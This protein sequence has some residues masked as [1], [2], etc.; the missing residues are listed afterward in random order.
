MDI[1]AQAAFATAT[2]QSVI[3]DLFSFPDKD[4]VSEKEVELVAAPAVGSRT[5]E[6]AEVADAAVEAV[7]TMRPAVAGSKH[8]GPGFTAYWREYM[9][10]VMAAEEKIN[11]LVNAS[12]GRLMLRGF[13]IGE[14]MSG[15]AM[16]RQTRKEIMEQV[17]SR[18]ER[19]F[20]P[21]SG[22]LS[23]SRCKHED[24]LGQ[25]WDQCDDES[26]D[27]DAVWN[28]LEGIYGGG[29]GVELG[30][31]QI[32]AKLVDEFGLRYSKPV[33]KANRLELTD[34]I[35]CEKRYDGTM[36]LSYRSAELVWQLHNAMSA[37]CE[38]AGDF[39]TA[40]KINLRSSDMRMNRNR[41]VV[42]R[43]R[44]DMGG[45]G[46]VM[47]YKSMTWEIYGDLG[48]QFQAFVGKYGREAIARNY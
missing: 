41:A 26:F 23:I 8:E 40:R 4:E 11:A 43:A 36:E 12:E 30:Y 48:D 18:A 39:E 37:F 17:Y 10:A 1:E 32:A 44:F 42:S 22:S 3:M 19:E 34:S 28:A 20:A 6:A 35:Y 31:K 2:P 24:L 29:Y 15:Y 21:Q 14:R 33:R 7:N 38:W 46:Y 25:S 5:A 16:L 9:E 13:R 47:F 27:P 45:V